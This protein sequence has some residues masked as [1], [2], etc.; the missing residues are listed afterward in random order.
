MIVSRKKIYFIFCALAAVFFVSLTVGLWFMPDMESGFDYAVVLHSNDGGELAEFYRLRRFFVP[1][2]DIPEHVR[3]A[4]VAAED[5]R[6]YS[7]HGIDIKGIARAALK[8]MSA[9]EVVEGGSTITQQLAKMTLKN[10]ERSFSRKF[11]E[12]IIAFWLEMKYSKDELL[13]LYLNLAYFGERV[14]GIEAAA[15]TYFN[16][17]AAKLNI[18]EAALLAG[19]QKAPSRD[20]PLKDPA[21]ARERMRAVLGRMLALKFISH[22]EYARALSEPLPERT[23][24]QRKYGASYFADFIRQRL[25]EKYGEAMHRRGFHVFS[26]IDAAMQSLAEQS[27]KEGVRIIELRTRPGVQAALVAIDT[28]SGE[29]KAMVGG[30][31]YD[32]SQFNRATMARRQPG[33]AFK[34]FVFAAALQKGMSYNDRILD[35]PISI[36]DSDRGR[37]WSPRNSEDEYY[38]DVP[39]KTALALSLNSATVRLSQKIGIDSVREMAERCGIQTKS[40]WPGNHPS[41]AL[42]SFEV[43]LLDMT[44]AYMAFATG[45][46]TEPM[47]YTLIRDKDGKDVERPLSSSREV[48]SPELVDKMKVLLR[49]PIES[50]IAGRAK[51]V[52]R[53]V[54]GKTGTTNDYSDAWFVGFD[55]HMAVG[56]W[57]GRDDHTTLGTE[58][59]GSETALAIWTQFM[60]KVKY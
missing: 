32:R 60:K 14:Y 1:S 35:A 48:F 59:G 24:F 2:R 37:W 51:A 20:S 43:T 9:K 38:G 39:L 13:G 12:M 29:I 25:S 19:L 41:M 28:A 4:F 7:H 50:G 26:T 18:P 45:K 40:A 34:P 23:Y 54:Y 11:R 6:F 21:R 52:G 15:R 42:G 30:T 33:S 10:K 36:W 47:A 31:D 53:T 55:D 56:V 5:N 44:A 58:E 49:G 16:K 46:K 8:N 3:N 57:V 17:P 27:V 22:D